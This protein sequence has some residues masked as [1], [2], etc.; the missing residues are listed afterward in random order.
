MTYFMILH[1]IT[2]LNKKEEEKK[3]RKRGEGQKKV[4]VVIYLKRNK[5]L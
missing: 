2:S 1:I 4:N 3:K 5:T